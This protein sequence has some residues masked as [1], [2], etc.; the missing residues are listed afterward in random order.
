MSDSI[1]YLFKGESSPVGIAWL[2]K[3]VDGIDG[4]DGGLRRVT[5]EETL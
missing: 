4:T 2:G 3:A 1:T 5:I